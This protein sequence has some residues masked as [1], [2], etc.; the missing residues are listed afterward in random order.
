MNVFTIDNEVSIR[1]FFFLAVFACMA[2]WEVIAPRR[3]LTSPKG[4]R[5]LNNIV[6]SFINTHWFDGFFQFQLSEWHFSA[7]KEAGAPSTMQ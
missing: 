2:A 5:W 3:I 1:L 4:I 6:I 7:R